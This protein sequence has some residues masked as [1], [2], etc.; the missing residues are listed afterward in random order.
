MRVSRE[1]SKRNYYITSPKVLMKAIIVTHIFSL[2]LC[3]RDQ[4]IVRVYGCLLVRANERGCVS[5]TH[6]FSLGLGERD[7]GIQGGEDS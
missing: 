7:R 3:E 2:G 6:I 4:G 1:S 5:V